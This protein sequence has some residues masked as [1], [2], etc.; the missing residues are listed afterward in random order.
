MISFIQCLK[1]NIKLL[2]NRK[3]TKYALICENSRQL[4]HIT[5]PPQIASMTFCD[6]L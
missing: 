2:Y 6:K 1:V 4:L 5:Q 3:T